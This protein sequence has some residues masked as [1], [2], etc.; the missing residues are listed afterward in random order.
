MTPPLP[1]PSAA[2]RGDRTRAAILDA[3]RRRFAEHGFDRTRLAEIAADAGVAEPT[4]ASLVAALREAAATDWDRADVS[5]SAHRF[6]E[7]R[8][9]AAMRDLAGALV[10]G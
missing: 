9:A 1:A 10:P 7:A 5:A 2:T 8:F 3:A 4:V 6:T